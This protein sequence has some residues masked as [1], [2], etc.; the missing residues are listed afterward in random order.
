MSLIKKTSKKILPAALIIIFVLTFGTFSFGQTSFGSY[1]TEVVTQNFYQ[2]LNQTTAPT[3]EQ[4]NADNQTATQTETKTPDENLT[5]AVFTVGNLAVESVGTANA[6]MTNPVSILE[7][8]NSTLNQSSPVQTISFPN[9]ATRPTSAPF[10]LTESGSAGS[11]GFISRSTDG[12]VIVVPGYNAIAGE[13]PA[14][15]ASATVNRIVGEIGQSGVTDISRAYSNVNTGN[16]FRSV[17]ST[18]GINIWSAGGNGFYYETGSTAT[19]L[20]TGNGRVANIFNGQLYI[21][22][23]STTFNG[24]GSSLGI[25]QIGTGLPTSGTP[26]LTNLINTGT[27]SSPYDYA[28]SPNG[29]TIYIADDRASASGGIQKWTSTT[30]AA[31]SFTLLYTLGSGATNIGARGLDV[32]FSGTNAVIY[33]TTAETTSDRLIKIT[34][35]GAGATATTLATAASNTI[36]RGV[37]F[38]PVAAGNTA[39]TI[40]VMP[41][42]LTDFGSVTVG[43]NSAAQTYTVSGS[44]LTAGITVTA[45][46]TDFQVSLDGMSF[47]DFVTVTQSSGT[48]SATISVRFTPQSAGMKMGNV[49]NASTGATTQNVAVSGTGVAVNTAPTF[50]SAASTTFTQNTAGTFTVTSSGSPTPTISLTGGT[51]P[52]GVTFTSN[53]NGTATL[54]GTPTQSGPFNL[55]FTATNSAGSVTQPF[56]LTVTAAPTIT[57]STN[58]LNDFGTVSV[59]SQ[60]V[61]Q[62]YTVSGSNLTANIIVTAPSQFQVSLDNTTFSNSVPVTQSSGSASATVYVRFAPTSGGAKTGNVANAS[63]GATTQNVAVTGTGQAAQADLAITQTAAPAVVAVNGTITYT[64]VITDSGAAVSSAFDATFDLPATG[65]TNATVTARGCFASSSISG[66]TVTFTGCPSLALNATTTLTVTIT[67]TT[68]GTLTSGNAIVDS[69]GA[70]AES[71][72]G[73]NTAAGVSTTVNPTLNGIVINEVYGGGGNVGATYTNDYIE[74][75]NNSGTAQNLGGFSVQYFS[76]GGTGAGQ[77]IVLPNDTLQPGGYYLIQGFSNGSVGT[78]LPT[79][80]TTSTVNLATANGNVVLYAGVTAVTGCTSSTNVIDKVGY[81]TGVCYEGA[82]PTPAPSVTTSAQRIQNGSDTNDN[83]VDFKVGPGTPGAVNSVPTPTITVNPTSLAFGNQTVNTT[84]AAMSYAL[85]G[86][87]LTANITVTAPTGYAV[88]TTQNGT[89]TPTLNIMQTGGTV[90]QTIYVQFTPTSAAAFNGNITNASTGATTQNVTVSGTGVTVNTA[91][92][93]TANPTAQTI[94]AG[95]TGTS[96]IAITDETPATVNLSG[97][98]NNQTLVPNA[99]IVFTGSG[100]SR[101]LTVTPVPGQTGTAIITVTATDSGSLTGTATYTLTINAPTITV[102]PATLPN[103]VTGTAYSQTITASGGAANYSFAVTAG[104]LPNNLTLASNGTLTGTPTVAG[105]FNFTITA[106]DANGFTGSQAY[107]VTINSA[108]AFTSANSTA[109]TVGTAGSFTVTTS[110]SPTPT[111]ITSSGALPSGVT[112]FNN[113]NGTA[114][115]SGTPAPGTA[116]SYPLTFTASNGIAPDAVQNFTLTVTAQPALSINDVTLNEGNSG[117]TTFTFTVSLNTPA[118]GGVTFNIATANGTATAGSDYTAKSLTGQTIPEGSSSYT[119]DVL[120]NGDTTAETN[121][122]FFV[123]VSNVTGATVADG[124]G[125]GTITNDDT[126][127]TTAPVISPYTPLPAKSSEGTSTLVV[128]VN[129]NV[130]VQSVSLIYAVGNGAP[131]TANCTPN[132]GST[133]SCVIS[134]TGAQGQMISYYVSATDSSNNSSSLPAANMPDAYTIGNAAV[135]SGTYTD[136][137]LN[138]GAL[139]G[140]VLALG[141]VNFNNVLTGNGNTLEIG[142]NGQL[143]RGPSAAVIVSGSVKK[144]LCGSQTFTFPVGS[145]TVL[146]LAPDGGSSV[147]YTPVTANI[148]A[149][150]NPSSLTVN[151]VDSFMPGSDN[152]NSV[153]RYWN[154]VEGG[155][156]T[157]DLSFTY[158]DSD[159]NGSESA[160]RVIKNENGT[161]SSFLDSTNNPATNTATV[162]GITNFSQWSVGSL[163]PTAADADIGG[164]VVNT[165]NRGLENVTVTLSGGLLTEPISVSTNNVGRYHFSDVPSGDTYILTVTSKRHTFGQPTQVFTLNGNLTN[166]NFVGTGW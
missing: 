99:N 85:T 22:T 165:H 94:T 79:P 158:D 88:S 83:S 52:N 62:N 157:A 109:F 47:S 80:N 2:L 121:E 3:G 51:L 76:F 74:L 126:A 135:Q 81:G 117:T 161:T 58:S 84:S 143:I 13:S 37:S 104:S 69:G 59:G 108:P 40:T 149:A 53:S 23:S 119:F 77:V 133:Y 82:G 114:T 102:A 89:Y 10:N 105:T 1:L 41:T 101:T 43:A 6:A 67:P 5:A 45:P 42:S 150:T 139:G 140:N 19:I 48:A 95:G 144:D 155:A 28:V 122:T 46:S 86:S 151:V 159:V 32:D 106:T 124:Q 115:L 111:T 64:I 44:N 78:A 68:A 7:Y 66:T 142:C 116:A 127:D 145:Q 96:T 29:L 131:T 129:D 107:S 61:S 17:A 30:G 123:N 27:G 148:T 50:T 120:V 26:T 91:P 39:P 25:Y 73:N 35:T 132:G 38:T 110:G 152:A 20:G 97:T 166:I 93:I 56:T 11:D 4:T 134:E 72:E 16:N 75:Y 164:R 136:L 33:A 14:S 160:Y 15:S 141:T 103:G 163:V 153:S 137:N 34:D 57:V 98:S 118:A 60:S 125:L 55:T 156:I 63:N 49:T 8:N 54:A 162:L 18:N 90:N 9:A 71:N 138:G 147:F 154:L 113:S 70:I 21:S 36:F 87:N 128:T 31:G 92:T 24:T 100:A 130:A 65:Y 12:T 146:T 112:F